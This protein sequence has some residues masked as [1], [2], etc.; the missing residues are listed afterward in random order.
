MP[1]PMPSPTFAALASELTRLHDAREAAIEQTLDA[2][3]SSHPPL[4]QLVLCCIGDRQRAARWLV[5]P[6][7]AFAGRSACD[8]LADGD[9][10][11]VWDQV[12]YKQFG[13]VAA[14]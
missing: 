2:L 7:R 14:V 1:R 6:Q 3:E 12:V 13:T 9:V 8:M 4:A 10:E 5:M 11:A